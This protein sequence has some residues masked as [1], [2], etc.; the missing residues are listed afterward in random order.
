ML[1]ADVGSP[2]VLTCQVG[3]VPA[4]VVTWL[5]DGSLLGMGTGGRCHP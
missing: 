2:L 5:K 3:G 1:D 4:P